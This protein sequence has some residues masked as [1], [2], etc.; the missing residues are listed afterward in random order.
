MNGVCF[1]FMTAA[2]VDD[3]TSRAERVNEAIG[4]YA[5]AKWLSSA[6]RAEGL[7]AGEP[8]VEDHGW[9]FDVRA[10]ERVY[11]CVCSIE[12]AEASTRA[13]FVSV[14]LTRSVWDRLKGRNAFDQADAVAATVERLL[15]RSTEISSLEK[16]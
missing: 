1:A 12:D 16:Q 6:L 9:D 2:F 14:D 3:E 13:A 5:L 10:G 11:L 15:L 7:E 8:W 4:G